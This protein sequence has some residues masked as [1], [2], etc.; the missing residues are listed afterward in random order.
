MWK[1]A[2]P[3]VGDIVVYKRGGSSFTGRVIG[4][5]G[6]QFLVNRNNVE[7][8]P[9]PLEEVVGRIFLSTRSQMAEEPPKPRA[10]K[11]QKAFTPADPTISKDITLAPDKT[12]LV[13][14]TQTQVVR[15]FEVANPGVEDC[16]V[17]YRAKIK[18]EGL[19]GR[20]YLEMLCGFPEFGEAFSRGLDKVISGTNDWASYQIPFFLKKG[21]KPDIIKLNLAVEGVGRVWIRDV[22]LSAVPPVSPQAWAPGVSDSQSATRQL[23]GHLFPRWHRRPI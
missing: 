10:P 3:E 19:Q 17:I 8:I 16:V 18:T 20:A 11:V 21:E 6:R 15:L 12:W 5:E 23:A 13:N 1:L 9:V 14:S 7:R 4:A 22:E 2:R